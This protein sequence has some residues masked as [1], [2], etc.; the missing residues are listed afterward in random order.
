M[1]DWVG[2]ILGW[3][4]QMGEGD[5]AVKHREESEKREHKTSHGS[6]EIDYTAEELIETSGGFAV[7]SGYDFGK[8]GGMKREIDIRVENGELI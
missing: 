5:G 7:A 8:D 1:L 2:A 6:E 4:R 3:V